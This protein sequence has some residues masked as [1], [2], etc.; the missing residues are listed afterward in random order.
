MVSLRRDLA[1]E[2]IKREDLALALEIV[3]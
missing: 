3:R 2:V 1:A